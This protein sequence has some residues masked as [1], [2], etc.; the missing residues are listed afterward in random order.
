MKVLVGVTTNIGLKLKAVKAKLE[1]LI[2][3]KRGEFKCLINF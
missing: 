3:A 2:Y 1:I